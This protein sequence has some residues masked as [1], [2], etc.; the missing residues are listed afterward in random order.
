MGNLSLEWMQK[1]L[2]WEE[3]EEASRFFRWS[4]E[5][6]SSLNCVVMMLK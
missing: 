5:L 4:S 1:V 6:N 2:I 3:T